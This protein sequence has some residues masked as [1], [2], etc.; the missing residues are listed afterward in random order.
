MNFSILYLLSYPLAGRV[1]S[2]SVKA[3]EEELIDCEIWKHVDG[4]RNV[5]VS[6]FGN[7]RDAETKRI[8]YQAKTKKGYKTVSFKEDGK[9]RCMFVHRLVAEA[10]LDHPEGCDQ[11]NHKDEVKDNNVVDNL[12]W[13]TAKYNVNYGT[14]PERR[15][16]SRRGTPAHNRKRVV[17]LNELGEVISVFDSATAASKAL[18]ICDE[19]ICNVANG[20]RKT[21]GG[22]RW[23]WACNPMVG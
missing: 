5:E 16:A 9:R 3:Q 15:A 18:G 8:R 13:C 7:V 1:K 19:H 10:F 4:T 22:F 23:M 11:V 12:E 17:Q 2:A 21:A 14:A 6:N 20:K